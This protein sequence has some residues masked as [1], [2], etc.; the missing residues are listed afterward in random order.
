M[1]TAHVIGLGCSG[2]A[3]AR[4][5]Q[6]QGWQVSLSD[7]GNKPQ[8]HPF[9]EKLEHQGIPVYLGWDFSLASFQEQ[10][11]VLPDVIVISPGVPWHSPNLEVARQAGI[12]VIGEVEVAWQQLQR[13]PWVGITGT[14][15]KT[16]TTA[17]TAAIF[18]TAGFN[19]PACG[20]IGYSLCEVA[21]NPTP[22]WV[23]AEI[24]SY[25]LES[26]PTLR[27]RLGI[28]TTLTPDH[29]ERHGTLEQYSATKAQLLDQ[30]DTPILNGDD[31]YLRTHLG[32]RWPQAWWVSCQGA[33]ALPNGSKQAVYLDDGWIFAEGKKLIPISMLKMPGSHNQQNLLLA[34]AA[35]YLAEIPLGAIAEGVAQFPGVPHR[36]EWICDW[37]GVAWIN[38]SKATNYDAAEIGLRA[39]AGPVILIAGGQAKIGEDQ[40][41]LA[42]IQGKVAQVLLIGDAADG[43]AQRFR[44]IG[45]GHYQQVETLEK[46]VHRAAELVA[47]SSV[48]TV[49]FSPACASFDQYQ[50]FEERGDHFRKLCLEL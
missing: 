2:M 15:G 48:K 12:S 25:Q 37:C 3:A 35:A 40:P 38:D 7:R 5:L 6:Q 46:A 41:W 9:K 30:A 22:D 13:V 33:A 36:L 26:K 21:L 45:Y 14:N 1:P 50:N 8:F 49:L 24:S 29:L 27:S 42:A 32:D 44:A 23:I 34:V 43:F 31:P 47:Q 10:N 11:V 39:V 4:L 16:T 17:L 18:Q 19:A 28:W 20:N